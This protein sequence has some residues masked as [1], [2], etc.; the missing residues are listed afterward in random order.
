MVFRPPVLSYA[1]PHRQ[2]AAAYRLLTPA[3]CL[4]L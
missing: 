1:E 4:L 2:L 3:F